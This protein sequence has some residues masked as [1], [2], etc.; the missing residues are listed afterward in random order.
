MPP[1]PLAVFQPPSSFGVQ[2][3]PALGEPDDLRDVLR[4]PELVAHQSA[5]RSPTLAER[6]LEE[7]DDACVGSLGAGN[8]SE[9]IRM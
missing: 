5:V 1:R 9:N 8:S 6:A 7:E 3:H 2:P 4:S